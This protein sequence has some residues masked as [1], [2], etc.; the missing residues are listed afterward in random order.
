MVEIALSLA[1]VAFALVAIM[2]VLPSGLTVQKEN[3]EDTLIDQE[4]QYWLQAIRTG[5]RGLHDLTNFV[6]SIEIIQT[7]KGPGMHLTDLSAPGNQITPTE[8][9]S[10]LSWPKYD[11]SKFPVVTNKI[12]AR[13]K[14]I[15]G[16]ASEKGNIT[17][18]SS[19]R[20]QLEVENTPDLSIPPDFLPPNRSINTRISQT[21][22]DVRLVLRWPVIQR[23]KGWL[24]GNNKKVFRAKIAGT[25]ELETNNITDAIRGPA[26][27]TN[28]TLIMPNQ[29]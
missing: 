28:Y 27:F 15:T 1:V 12:V 5:A 2:G 6:E 23:G 14:P 16:L 17:N 18:E 25:R 20:Y 13:V 9:I 7:P 21:L 26:P 24:V 10:M 11:T 3:R 8:L 4:G 29:F 19:F 22:H